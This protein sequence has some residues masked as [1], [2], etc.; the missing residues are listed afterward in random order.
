MRRIIKR[1]MQETRRSGGKWIK[2]L[3]ISM[4]E[5]RIWIM[6]KKGRK[7]GKGMEYHNI[8]SHG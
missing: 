7:D 2:G 6:R 4:E 5:W 8:D 1:R 3:G